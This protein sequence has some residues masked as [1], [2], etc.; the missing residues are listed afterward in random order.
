MKLFGV[1]EQ[2]IIGIVEFPPA[3]AIKITMRR[4]V[5]SGSPGDSDVYGAQQHAPLLDLLVPSLPEEWRTE[6]NRRTRL[7]AHNQA[8]ESSPR[9]C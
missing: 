1:G 3:Y 6:S 8:L 5:P 2:D 9:A 4:P 7:E